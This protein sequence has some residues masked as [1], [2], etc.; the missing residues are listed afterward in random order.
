MHKVLRK[1]FAHNVSNSEPV[2]DGYGLF[3]ALLVKDEAVEKSVFQFGF[4][5][6]G[7]K[8]LFLLQ[9]SVCIKSVNV[10]RKLVI[11]ALGKPIEEIQLINPRNNIML[12]MMIFNQKVLYETIVGVKIE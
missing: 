1:T 9:K 3:I 12:R 5:T 11:K 6:N 8:E 7:R 2:S 4:T 10:R